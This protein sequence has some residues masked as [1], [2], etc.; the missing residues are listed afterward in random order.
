MALYA[1]LAI[2]WPSLLFTLFGVDEKQDTNA[3]AWLGLSLSLNAYLSFLTS[4]S[5]VLVLYCGPLFQLVFL[6]DIMT[7]CDLKTLK[8]FIVL[9][10]CQEVV[11]RGAL[12]AALLGS[13]FTPIA[14]IAI[15]ACASAVLALDELTDMKLVKKEKTLELLRGLLTNCVF[16]GL[17]GAF[18][19][20]LL[21][22]TGSLCG[23]ITAQCFLSFMGPPDLGFLT[24][25]SHY[26]F[27]ARGYVSAVYLL[28]LVGFY[29]LFP[30]MIDQTLFEPFH[31][32]LTAN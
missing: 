26:A 13:G 1:I 11:M 29:F 5:L 8:D 25:P 21:V 31:Y 28:G 30:L 9:P 4:F 3:F 17:T 20:R 19:A 22:A 32:S 10:I 2:T 18:A 27:K 6:E 12:V 16:Q 7:D 24:N 15:S 23:P 14:A